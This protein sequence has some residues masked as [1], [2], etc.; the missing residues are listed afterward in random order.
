[1]W[2]ASL[3]AED[4]AL[5]ADVEALLAGHAVLEKAGYLEHGA[6]PLPDR[7]SLAGLAV[8]SYTLSEPIGQGG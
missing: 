2:L 8:G 4:P 5:A 7:Q 1:M 6:G 3:R